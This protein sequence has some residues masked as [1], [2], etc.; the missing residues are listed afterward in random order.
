MRYKKIGIYT[1]STMLLFGSCSKQL[2]QN[3]PQTFSD[4]N[5]Y[6]FIEDVQRGVNGAFG[7]YATKINDLWKNS[8]TSDEAK[9]GDDNAGTGLITYRFQYGADGTSGSDVI[10]GYYGNYSMIDQINRILPKINTV[11][12][13]TPERKNELTAH[14]LALRGIGHFDLLE[15]FCGNYSASAPGVAIMTAFDAAAK[16]QRNTMG[17]VLAQIKT[18]LITAKDLLPVTTSANF[19]DTVFNQLN[20]TAYQARIA[21]WEGDYDAA[22][23][24]STEVINSGILSLAS[25]SDY[26]AIWTDDSY[27]ESLFRIRFGPSTALGGLWTS[28]GN[29]AQIAP[30]DKLT[31]SYD[32]NDIRLGAFIGNNSLG[33]RYVK[34]H[35]LS[36]RGSRAVDLKACRLSEIYLIR[37]EAY[38][39]KSS[40]DV[41]AGT[42][43]LNDLRAQR[44]FGYTPV[45]FPNAQALIDAVLEERFKELCFEG[46]RFFDLRRNN[47]PVERL[48]SDA[49]PG[50]QTLDAGNFR[51][52]YPIP[53]DAIQ[54][55]PNTQQNPGY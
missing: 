11:T 14:L 12:G 30:S 13:G 51:F 7:G 52:I 45:N 10:G 3:N 47:R 23:N 15:G 35:S 34:K 43:D 49:S 31:N 5:A 37:A 27:S 1:L 38:A 22:I 20:I 16:P 6:L 32:A 36:S 39:K 9:I 33:H 24:Y 41:A 53:F 42:A 17:E 4:Q 19:S 8:L 55:N 50:W 26:E 44:I 40:P 48:A 18:D 21:L 29:S 2:E 25:G 28:S 46:F 54:A